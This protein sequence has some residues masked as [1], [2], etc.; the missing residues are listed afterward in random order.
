MKDENSQVSIPRNFDVLALGSLLIGQLRTFLN[1]DSLLIFFFLILDREPTFGDHSMM[2]ID[3]T[4]LQFR[5]ELRI[6]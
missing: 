3:R 4:Y 2:A 1:F 5:L 6:F